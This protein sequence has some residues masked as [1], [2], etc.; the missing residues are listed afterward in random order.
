MDGSASKQAKV[1]PVNLFPLLIVFDVSQQVL[2]LSLSLCLYVC[3]YDQSDRRAHDKLRG[4]ERERTYS[5]RPFTVGRSVG[6]II[7]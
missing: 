2:S 1:N 7:N 3:L 6:A 4:R 5:S